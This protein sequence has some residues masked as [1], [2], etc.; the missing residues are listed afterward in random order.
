MTRQY[1]DYYDF[2]PS[3]FI[4]GYP[5]WLQEEVCNRREDPA[6]NCL[7]IYI[8][9]GFL[10][11]RGDGR[12]FRYYTLSNNMRGLTLEDYGR[13]VRFLE[14]RNNIILP[15]SRMVKQLV[16]G[17]NEVDLGRI[18]QYTDKGK[19]REKQRKWNH[20]NTSPKA[21]DLR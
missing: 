21:K 15:K 16:D 10:T 17:M 9:I 18:R 4:D 7:P 11:P 14:D 2:T 12:S 3:E 19:A 5:A 13:A 20:E 6:D 1:H 8:Q